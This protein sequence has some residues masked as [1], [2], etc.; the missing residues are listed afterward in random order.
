M[1]EE[2]QSVSFQGSEILTVEVDGTYYV[3]MKPVCESIGLNWHGQRQR[4]SRHPILNPVAVMITATGFDSKKYKMLMLPIKDMQGWLFTVD[5]NRV[6][7]EIKD[8]LIAYQKECYEVLYDYW[9]KDVTKLEKIVIERASY[10]SELQVFLETTRS[11]MEDEL[12]EGCQNMTSISTSMVLESLFYRS[13]DNL[14]L[15][16]DV[17]ETANLLYLTKEQV[18]KAIKKLTRWRLIISKKESELKYKVCLD[19][20]LV[21]A[22][23]NH[24]RRHLFLGGE[25]N[26]LS[27]LK[28]Q[29]QSISFFDKS[30]IE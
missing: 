24:S 18:Y 30:R 22:M 12:K 25:G 21:E 9:N 7:P 19:Y 2:M 27:K 23:L 10:Y 1:I 14:S 13:R 3:A 5:S 16:I 20:D 17:V 15:D 28:N 6:N 4:I 29:L 11:L 8:R 26:H